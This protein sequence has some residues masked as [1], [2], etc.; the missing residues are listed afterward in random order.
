MPITTTIQN[1][2][3]SELYQALHDFS[4]TGGDVIKIAL[5]TSA[6]NIDASTSVYS[7]T[8]EVVGTG[9][10]AGGNTLV[11][12]DPTLVGSTAV[13]DFNDTVWSA[14]TITAAGALIYNS[15]NGNR[16]IQSHDF[17]GDQSSSNADFTVRFPV[18]DAAN[19]IQRLA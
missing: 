17:G 12:Q 4:A 2:F 19:A 14:S 10:T 15:T 5:Y 3:K 1:S 18:A 16:C 11:N 13:L 7:T 6:A 8:G 9:Y